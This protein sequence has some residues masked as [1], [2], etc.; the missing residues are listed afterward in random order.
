MAARRL[1]R[2]L[3]SRASGNRALRRPLDAIR[4][5]PRVRAFARRHL[6]V[7]LARGTTWANVDGALRLL[8][9]DP[10]G[11]IVFGPWEGDVETELLYWAPFVRWA[12]DHFALDPARIAVVSA[13]GAGHWYGDSCGVYADTVAAFPDA[14]VFRPEPVLALVEDYRNGTAAPR[15]LL[16]RARHVR[17][18]P[19][20]GLAGDSLPDAYVAVSLAPSTAFPTSERNRGL[21]ES[22]AQALSAAGPAVSVDETDTLSAQH[23]LLAGATGLVAAY[24]G[25][26]LLG[27]L[28]G[29]PVVAL[30]SA[31]GQVVEPDVDLALRVVSEL[32]GSLTVL[33][34]SD[35]ALLASVLGGRPV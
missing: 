21:A 30:R 10:R 4:T 26:A 18:A 35:L 32:G 33:D 9:E 12:Q 23:S 16:K 6:D 22:L 20:G 31:D 8:A 24:S 28:S 17:L 25:L 11:R 19:P 7:L 34:V 29:V 13:N 5:H 27:A 15:P 3:Y 2:A 14:A 1:A